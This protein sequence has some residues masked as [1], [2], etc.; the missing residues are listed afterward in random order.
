MSEERVL[1][2]GSD[3]TVAHGLV[4]VGLAGGDHIAPLVLLLGPDGYCQRG[5][6]VAAVL[7]G[8]ANEGVFPDL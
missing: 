1:L 2:G 6:E 4:I 8:V 3:H 5:Q 7:I